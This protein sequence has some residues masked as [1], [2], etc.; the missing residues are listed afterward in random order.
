MLEVLEEPQAALG[1]EV[2]EAELQDGALV[3]EEG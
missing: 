2:S 3:R 1:A